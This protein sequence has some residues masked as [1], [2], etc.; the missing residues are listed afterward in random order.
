MNIQAHHPAVAFHYSD[1]PETGIR[2]SEKDAFKALVCAIIERAADDVRCLRR[3]GLLNP[4][5]SLIGNVRSHLAGITTR[6]GHSSA[7]FG[8]DAVAFFRDGRI[9]RAC[10]LINSPIVH[11]DRIRQHVLGADSG[12]NLD[13]STISNASHR[14]C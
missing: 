6:S 3:Q 4:D 7:H 13:K 5:G 9:D 2:V 11:A 10:D 12:F 14:G 1:K 8:R